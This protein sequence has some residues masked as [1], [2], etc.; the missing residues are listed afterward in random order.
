MSLTY[1]DAN[2]VSFVQYSNDGV[3]DTELWE[4]LYPTRLWLLTSGDGAKTVYYQIK[5]NVGITSSSY[6]DTIILE[7]PSPTATP[8]R[9]SYSTAPPSP[10]VEPA[11]TLAPTA[12]ATPNPSP[13]ATDTLQSIHLPTPLP[14][15]PIFYGLIVG[16]IILLIVI[17]AVLLWKK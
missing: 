1:S 10:T 14:A 9:S 15:N 11:S 5:D 8:P 3:W 13:T 6:S 2:S 4:T 16:T 7:L 12:T 17:L